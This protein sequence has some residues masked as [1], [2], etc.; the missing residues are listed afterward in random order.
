MHHGVF[1]FSD[2]AKESYENM[3]E[4]VDRADQYIAAS[5]DPAIHPAGTAPD[6]D[7]G[8]KADL[9]QLARIRQEVS[10]ARGKAQLACLNSTVAAKAFADRADVA[11]VATRGP[12]TPDH[13]I[14]TKRI[15]LILGSPSNKS[16]IEAETKTQ[17]QT[18]TM[19]TIDL[20]FES[21]LVLNPPT[22]HKSAPSSKTTDS[23]LP[24][25]TMAI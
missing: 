23:T 1:T 21:A 22:T 20:K 2:D 3:I 4:L 9:R 16:K 6:L 8:A 5:A 13:V 11:S 10:V 17:A 25:T 18:Q 19:L 12:I 7:S 14:R 24:P 15:P